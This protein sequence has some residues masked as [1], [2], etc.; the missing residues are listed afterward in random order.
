[1]I[2]KCF[3]IVIIV[4]VIATVTVIIMIILPNLVHS[5]FY[6]LFRKVSSACANVENT[7]GIVESS[8]DLVHINIGKL[9]S[10][11]KIPKSSKQVLIS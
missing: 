1:M 3:V 7:K 8:Q 9:C 4:V 5:A 10:K 6:V 11:K 2:T